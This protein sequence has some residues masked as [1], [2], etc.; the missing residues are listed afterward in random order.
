VIGITTFGEQG[1]QGG[2]YR[3][4]CSHGGS[5]KAPGGCTR[6][7]GNGFEAGGD[8][9][10]SLN[11]LLSF[12]SMRSRIHCLV[13]S[14]K[15]STMPFG[16]GDFEIAIITPPLLVPDGT[17]IGNQGWGRK[18]RNERRKARKAVQGTFRPLDDLKNWE[19]YV[20][21]YQSIY[22]DTRYAQDPRDWRIYFQEE[23]GCWP[24][25]GRIWRASHDAL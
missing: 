7:D 6:E 25:P 19:E 18:R 5:Y 14:S 12:R 9:A 15:L 3:R 4:Y 23:P 2:G 22:V 24:E 13:R 20:G 10:S 1:P 21:G 16:L 11:Q 17:G 8:S